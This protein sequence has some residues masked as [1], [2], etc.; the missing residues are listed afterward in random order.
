MRC[1]RITAF[2]RQLIDPGSMLQASLTDQYATLFSQVASLARNMVRD[3]DPTV[4]A[5]RLASRAEQMC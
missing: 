2:T 4:R 5:L 1:A 3:L